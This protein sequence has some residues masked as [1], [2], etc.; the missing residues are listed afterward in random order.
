MNWKSLAKRLSLVALLM[1]GVA[2]T[3]TGGVIYT[4]FDSLSGTGRILGTSPMPPFLGGGG[5]YSRAM[6]FT[7]SDDATFD[8]ASVYVV[9]Q[10]GTNSISL[11][12]LNGTATVPGTVL[13][14]TAVSPIP[15]IAPVNFTSPVTWMSST[16]SMLQAGS[17]YWLVASAPSWVEWESAT[18][19]SSLVSLSGGAWSGVPG[20]LSLQ[21]TG[22]PTT[23]PAPV[24]EPA[25]MLLLGSGL[26][27]MAGRAWRKR[28]A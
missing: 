10:S 19:G 7:V 15:V 12:L 4:N 5:P 21:V 11:S 28:K 16:H 14:T 20:G 27:G 3:A 13:E 23:T 6:S 2:S 25:S 8:S 1:V 9:L 26:I 18:T 17:T 22:S 24:P